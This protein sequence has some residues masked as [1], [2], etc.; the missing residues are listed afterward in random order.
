MKAGRTIQDLSAEIEQQMETKKDYVTDTRNLQMH[1]SESFGLRLNIK[2]VGDFSL[3][4]TGHRQLAGRL[5]IPQPYYR[6]MQQ[7]D[8]LLLVNNANGWLAKEPKRRMVRTMEGNVR[9]FLSDKYRPL[10]NHDL[11]EAIFPELAASGM[12]LVSCEVTEKKLY[13]KAVSKEVQSEIKVGDAVQAGVCITNSE[14][15][16]GHVRVDPL[17]YRLV[18][19]NGMIVN[20]ASLKQLHVGRTLDGDEGVEQFFRDETRKADDRAF[21]LKVRDVVRGTFESVRFEK[22]V[23]GL[24]EGTKRLIDRDPAEVVEVTQSRYD[25]S[26][27]ERGGVLHAL[28]MGADLTQYGLANA[29]TR[30]SQDIEDYD[31]AT[32]LERVGGE[33]AVLPDAE[34][35]EIAV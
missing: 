20:D 6:R 15:G 22:L 23:D 33:I 5:G 17:I 28:I 2:G 1:Y 30:A 26:D 12:D 16:L 34:W 4:S 9:A 25:L 3:T 29:I 18:C 13:L 19:S 27:D 10:D 31:R 32:E 8:P 24:R 35:K 14:V 11:C 21:W 7:D